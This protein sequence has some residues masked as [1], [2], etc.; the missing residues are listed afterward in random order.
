MD[1]QRRR[2]IYLDYLRI[3]ST[4]FVILLHCMGPYIEQEKLYGN[5]IWYFCIIL[6]PI[7]RTAVPIFFM[8]S[9]Y[10]SLSDKRT[11]DIKSFYLSRAK[12]VLLPFI[13]WD[14]VYYLYSNL[15]VGQT[16]SFARFFKELFYQGSSYHF[17]YVYTL[18]AVLLITPFLKIIVDRCSK[19]QLVWLFFIVIFCGTIR[20]FLNTT[21]SLSIYLSEPL[22]EGYIG[23]FLLGYIL[24]HY[25]ISVISRIIIY[26]SGILG[27]A[28]GIYMNTY[29]SSAAGIHLKANGGYAIN[30]YMCAAALFCLFKRIKFS[31][32]TKFSKFIIS[33]SAVTYGIY[34][35]HPLI[36]DLVRRLRLDIV[37]SVDITVCFALSF[38]AGGVLILILSRIK[39]IRNLIT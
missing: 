18:S 5:N 12:R 25:D 15:S 27:F 33:F 38:V 14:V 34:L 30:Q 21:F 31:S 4:A 9:G 23:F 35:S 17:W 6:N 32:H 2:E 39:L 11:L 36:L 24:G 7:V 10:L 29:L 28:Y 13:V 26:I 22:F 20:P 37:P 1:K 16:I 8:M 19:Q 3:I